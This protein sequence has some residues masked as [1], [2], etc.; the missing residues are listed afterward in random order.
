[1]IEQPDDHEDEDQRSPDVHASPV[2]Q[3]RSS[4]PGVEPLRSPDPST[5]LDELVEAERISLMQ[6]CSIMRCLKE[7]LLYSDDGDGTMHSEVAEVSSRLLDDSISRLE[8]IKG[9]IKERL[10]LFA[11]GH[12]SSSE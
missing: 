9:R 5:P 11:E 12:A 6:V 2:N 1:M 8:V 4:A 10:V 7:V 3:D